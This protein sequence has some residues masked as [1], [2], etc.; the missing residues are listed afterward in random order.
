[1]RFLSL[2]FVFFILVK[3]SLPQDFLKPIFANKYIQEELDKEG[4]EF[5]KELKR[6]LKV[7]GKN[8]FRLDIENILKKENCLE[9]I[10]RYEKAIKRA[11]K[12]IVEEEKKRLEKFEKEYS[13]ILSNAPDISDKVQVYSKWF[14]ADNIKF[15]HMTLDRAFI[16]NKGLPLLERRINPEVGLSVICY[17]E[18]KI[19]IFVPLENESIKDFDFA[20]YF[21]KIS[22]KKATLQL[23]KDVHK[24]EK[25]IEVPD[26]FN[27]YTVIVENIGNGRY[28]LTF[29][30]YNVLLIIG[31][32]FE[33]ISFRNLGKECTNKELTVNFKPEYV[34]IGFLSLKTGSVKWYKTKLIYKN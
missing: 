18:N 4:E 32:L 13:K 14:K 29:P 31:G 9:V 33:E 24:I 27:E 28:K 3:P 7:V 20:V 17:T 23:P 16:K 11:N 2:I 10:K 26:S 22:L 8:A 34:L 6:C 21:G 30:T 5:K 1:M 25:H 15:L 19:N 12:R